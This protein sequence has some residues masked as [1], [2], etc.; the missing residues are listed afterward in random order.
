MEFFLELARHYDLTL[1]TNHPFPED[2]ELGAAFPVLTPGDFSVQGAHF[3]RILYCISQP[4]TAILNELLPTFPGVVIS[5]DDQWAGFAA[6]ERD[7]F[8]SEVL[9]TPRTVAAHCH[10]AIEEAYLYGVAT[11][12]QS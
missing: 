1:V 6:A 5:W 7:E 10:S 8:A 2:D 3:D 4:E 9:S 11:Q 12:R